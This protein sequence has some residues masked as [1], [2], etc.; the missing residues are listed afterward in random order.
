M[1]RRKWGA[2]KGDWLLDDRFVSVIEENVEGKLG[3][4]WKLNF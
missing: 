2:E 3:I 4:N 1:N